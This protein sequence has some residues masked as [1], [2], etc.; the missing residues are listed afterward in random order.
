MSP[1]A[2]PLYEL[3]GR[4]RKRLWGHHCG[5]AALDAGIAWV[6][7]L[8]LGSLAVLVAPPRPLRLIVLVGGALAA[9]LL[10][11]RNA[12]WPL[13]RTRGGAR[14]ARLVERRIPG[15]RS[16]LLSAL[17]LHADLQLPKRRRAFS[18]ALA[19]AHIQEAARR[20]CEADLGPLVPAEALRW[21][22]LTFAAAVAV[23]GMVVAV[24]PG[25]P[26]ANLMAL[27]RGARA[28][29]AAAE[30]TSD[31]P[32]VADIEILTRAPV[33]SGLPPRRVT[34]SDGSVRGLRGSVVELRARTLA[35]AAEAFL[36][37]KAPEEQRLGAS[38]TGGER[39]HARMVLR[40][41]GSYR[42][43][44]EGGDG[45]QQVEQ[46]ER[47]IEVLA[48]RTPAVRLLEPATDMEVDDV[49]DLRVGYELKDDFGFTRVELVV[50]FLDGPGDV[51][52]LPLVGDTLPGKEFRSEQTLSLAALKLQPG[53]RIRVYVEAADNDTVSGPKTGTSGARVITV[54]SRQE[55]HD[56]ATLLA[57]Q[58]WEA[59]IRSLATR[60][61]LPELKQP[62]GWSG[63]AASHE[64]MMVE[65]AALLQMVGTLL[66]Q[67]SEDPLATTAVVATFGTLR[68]R[69]EKVFRR[70]QDQHA[71]LQELAG[72]RALAAG[73]GAMVQLRVANERG[74]K[75]LEGSILAIDR[76]LDRQQVAD[77]QELGRE[78]LQAKDRLQALLR[79]YKETRDPALRRQIEREIR[80]L[81]QHIADLMRRLAA[82]MKQLPFEHMNA[83]AL[84]GKRVAEQAENFA[85]SMKGI[86]E[87]L[88][89]DDIQG[90]LDE[91]ERFGSTL[92]GMLDALDRDARQM[93]ND[94][95]DTVREELG[96]IKQEMEQLGEAEAQLERET[97]KLEEEMARKRREA[98]EERLDEVLAP[99]LR[100]LDGVEERLAA[101]PQRHLG[102]DALDSFKASR[103]AADHLRADLF[104]REIAQAAETA[105]ALQN[106]TVATAARAS[107]RPPARNPQERK[108][109]AATR[110]R[111][112]EASTLAGEIRRELDKLLRDTPQPRPSGA[113]R[114]Q[115]ERL[116]QRQ[117]ELAER[118]R[119][120]EER[121][122]GLEGGEPLGTGEMAEGLQGA[123]RQME[124][125]RQR[126]SKGQPRQARPPEQK[127]AGQLKAVAQQIRKVLTP[128]RQGG[129]P[130]P[131][132]GSSR[133]DT[134]RVRIPKP[135]EYRSDRALRERLLEAM[136]QGEP[137]VYRE[138]NQGY[139]QELLKW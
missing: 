114:K 33:Y 125:A 1:Q 48:D 44:V 82:Q 74:V 70:E 129:K 30:D 124:Q 7:L 100:R 116:S 79:R 95:I 84:K 134:D 132:G 128:G 97:A 71:R 35:P 34:G 13:L 5:R 42:F 18:P 53:D 131:G 24:S 99:I 20:A 31:S 137:E 72:R 57:R 32:L 119:R 136:K 25:G 39:V 54:R 81:R 36:V 66:D 26:G 75:E 138:Q 86:E 10:I 118:G 111:L 3:L 63:L 41:G 90:A 61:E 107:L 130:K 69:L 52:R 8:A 59:M 85:E 37:L 2:Q 91:L 121:L 6:G 73:G 45:T 96:A 47:R 83:D 12:V 112:Q 22:A 87:R 88:A 29:V 115:A 19:N 78:L 43:G 135:E 4:S 123:L 109:Q 104:G 56:A 15:L 94:G 40:E 120:A 101:T 64:T 50:E 110:R 133:P 126:L 60:L 127:A 23:L 67:L 65:T 49:A 68:T 93:Q 51:E 28:D 113:D 38:V 76:L 77:L 102:D 21:R 55:R 58:A 139:Y 117:Q 106:R 9:A 98:L 103:E 92:Q 11:L 27:V 16:W 80:R 122:R 14:L 17:E 105:Q 89:A 108:E 62:K 46:R